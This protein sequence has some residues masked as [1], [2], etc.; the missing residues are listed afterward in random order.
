MDQ[1]EATFAGV[2]KDFPAE[3]A[4]EAVLL[5][6]A[7][8]SQTRGREERRKIENFSKTKKKHF[9]A[10]QKARA[11]KPSLFFMHFEI[12]KIRVTSY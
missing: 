1:S 9:L 10:D 11:Y 12:G 5:E 7:P 6:S 8:H 3:Q 4:G 2:C